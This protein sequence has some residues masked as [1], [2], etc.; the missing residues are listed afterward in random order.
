MSN[1]IL[2]R[3][4]FN[5]IILQCRIYPCQCYFWYNN[6]LSLVV[7][8][9][10]APQ[11]DIITIFQLVTFIYPIS[12]SLKWRWNTICVW[13]TFGRRGG[14]R[15]FLRT[16]FETMFVWFELRKKTVVTLIIG[17]F[18]TLCDI[19]SWQLKY[20]FL[21]SKYLLTFFCWLLNFGFTM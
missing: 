1:K 7:N 5:L 16:L 10:P 14:K 9:L 11:Q 17:R 19:V 6:S 12:M 13:F 15:S 4:I 2:R 8:Q 21:L 20:L 3:K 18:P